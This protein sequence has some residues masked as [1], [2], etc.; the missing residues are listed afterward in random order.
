MYSV[1][2]SSVPRG[3]LLSAEANLLENRTCIWLVRTRFE[4]SLFPFSYEFMLMREPASSTIRFDSWILECVTHSSHVRFL[5]ASRLTV[6]VLGRA[7][8]VPSL[9]EAGEGQEA[10]QKTNK[11]GNSPKARYA[12]WRV[13]LTVIGRDGFNK[14]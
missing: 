7:H 10:Q 11:P 13:C 8:K 5:G 14:R 4:H 1:T 6:P 3:P 2:R 12:R 9:M